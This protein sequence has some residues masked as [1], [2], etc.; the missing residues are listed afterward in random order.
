MAKKK[1]EFKTNVPTA[2]L[3]EDYQTL[4][5]AYLENDWSLVQT[6]M[7]CLA[8]SIDDH[9]FCTQPVHL[10]PSVSSVIAP[11]C[12]PGIFYDDEK[13]QDL[14]CKEGDPVSFAMLGGVC[15]CDLSCPYYQATCF[16]EKMHI[17][18]ESDTVYDP[19]NLSVESQMV[20][21]FGSNEAISH[22]VQ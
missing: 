8:Q 11:S 16:P 19:K 4:L 1:V 20:D 3:I 18:L 2:N 15:Q 9:S 14:Q 13:K 12:A 21:E 6:V 7:D 17:I 5:K 22:S 10:R